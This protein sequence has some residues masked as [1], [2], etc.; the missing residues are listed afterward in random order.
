MSLKARRQAQRAGRLAEFFAATSL[1]L[2]G[3]RIVA[4]D[5]RCKQGEIDLVAR[6]G[7]V[8]AFIEVKRRDGWTAAAD[9]VSL[10]QRQRI[11]R[12]A[13]FFLAQHP[14]LASL[15]PRFDAILIVPWRPPSHIRDAWRID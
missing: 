5:W 11:G 1:R 12:A 7:G 10:R 2:R 8:V 6:R 3:W 4:R 15:Q 13:A 9:A 14:G